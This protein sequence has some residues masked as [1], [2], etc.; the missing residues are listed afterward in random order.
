MYFPFD[1]YFILYRESD[2]KLQLLPRVGVR[3]SYYSRDDYSQSR[4]YR[5]LYTVRELRESLW[6]SLIKYILL[7]LRDFPTLNRLQLSIIHYLTFYVGS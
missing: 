6:Y 7:S 5:E 3:F 2:T 1:D 4:I